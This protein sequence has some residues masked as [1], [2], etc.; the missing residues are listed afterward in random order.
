[1]IKQTKRHFCLIININK[2]AYFIPCVCFVLYVTQSEGIPCVV[3]FDCRWQQ[4]HILHCCWILVRNFGRQRALQVFRFGSED[5]RRAQAAK[6]QLFN[7]SMENSFNSRYDEYNSLFHSVDKRRAWEAKLCWFL[8]FHSNS[9]G[10]Q[11]I[12]DACKKKKQTSE[13]AYSQFQCFETR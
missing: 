8:I 3:A 5:S 7:S 6:Y 9:T 11:Y 2:I 4:R 13:S 1:M 10:M 12:Q